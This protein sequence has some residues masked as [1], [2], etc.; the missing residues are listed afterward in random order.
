MSQ[1]VVTHLILVVREAAKNKVLFSV[2]RPLRPYH[3]PPPPLELSGDIFW[4]DCV[5]IF[6]RASKK[7]VFS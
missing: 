1:K 5:G 6:F 4:G 3:P 7:V 2:N